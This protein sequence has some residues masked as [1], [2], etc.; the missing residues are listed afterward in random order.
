M[1]DVH[2]PNFDNVQIVSDDLFPPSEPSPLYLLTSVVPR[3]HDVSDQNS[4][5]VNQVRSDRVDA[6]WALV[7]VYARIFIQVITCRCVRV[8]VYND[9]LCQFVI[10][11]R[12]S[13]SML[14]KKQAHS[15]THSSSEVRTTVLC[16]DIY[17]RNASLSF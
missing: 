11:H 16:L 3:E 15:I 4:K 7:C 17:N 10:L 6:P 9:H 12:K 13:L 1:Y 14:Y 8:G 5:G 2:T